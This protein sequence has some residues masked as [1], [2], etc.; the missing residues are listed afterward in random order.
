M[1]ERR[2]NDL[3]FEKSASERNQS[4]AAKPDVK[5]NNKSVKMPGGQIQ[6]PNVTE[7]KAAG[8]VNN[9]HGDQWT[10]PPNVGKYR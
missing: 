8:D 6:K 1:P 9:G 5:S 7:A 4:L 2:D 10:Q 3:K